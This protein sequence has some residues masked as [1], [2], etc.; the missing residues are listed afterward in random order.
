MNL[1]TLF[2]EFNSKKVWVHTCS[3]DHKNALANYLARGMKIYKSEKI[4]LNLN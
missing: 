3:L 1:K 2:T 4:I